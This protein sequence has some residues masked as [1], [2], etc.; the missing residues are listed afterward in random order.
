MAELSVLLHHDVG[1]ELAE[2]VRSR[3]SEP[4]RITC[5]SVADRHAYLA[6]LETTDVLFHVL[7]PVTERELAAA[8]RLR[9][10]QK[11]GVGVNT[12]DLAACRRRSISVCNM[13]G[14]NAPA[15]VEATLLL[16][17]AA[18]RRLPDWHA[19]TTGGHGWPTDP[20][21]ADTMGELAGRTVGLVGYGDIA[22]RLD[23]VLRALGASVLH[24]SRRSDR[25][26]WRPIDELLA[27][28]DVVSL[29]L[30]LTDE[31]RAIIDQRRFDLL[32]PGTVFVNTARGGLV[33]QEA[34]VDALQTGRLRA[35]GLDVFAEEPVDRDSPL[36]SLPNVVL[37]PHVAWLTRETMARCLDVGMENV[38]RLAQGEEL[39]HRVV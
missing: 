32:K 7:D 11:L 35:V 26:G 19:R 5:C 23:Q 24:H 25:K 38:G 18:L 3:A 20:L 33:E 27:E 28:A 30:P 2:E 14:T 8:P 39:L 1:P 36:L 34:L 9:L 13:P 22:Q 31:T 29:H 15:V 37:M 21:L 16:M 4:V 10:V 6:A 12:I 17:L